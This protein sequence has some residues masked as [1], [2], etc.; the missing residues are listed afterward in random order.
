MVVGG[1]A[2]AE[3]QDIQAHPRYTHTQL[4]I[5]QN[6][7]SRITRCGN[8]EEEIW[9]FLIL[10]ASEEKLPAPVYQRWEA[11]SVLH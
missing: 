11:G 5:R 8:G 3:A 2:A 7:D 10:H 9:G 6:T 1:S 4:D